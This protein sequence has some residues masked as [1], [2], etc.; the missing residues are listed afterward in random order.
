[1]VPKHLELL[2]LIFT[3]L[4]H[5]LPGFPFAIR[6]LSNPSIV[7]S[8]PIFHHSE[9]KLAAQLVKSLSI[10][11]F[12][13]CLILDTPHQSVLG[14][15]GSHRLVEADVPT[16]WLGPLQMNRKQ[17]PLE[18]DKY[19]FESSRPGSNPEWGIYII[20]M[21]SAGICHRNKVN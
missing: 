10:R 7:P 6:L 14:D 2:L 15:M 17:S 1:M 3:T 11:K 13:Y 9:F 12:P 18:L 8:E 21:V 5:S 4:Y 20:V 19:G 16:E